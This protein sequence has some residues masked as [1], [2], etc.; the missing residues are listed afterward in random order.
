MP[1][2]DNRHEWLRGYCGDVMLDRID[3]V[4]TQDE[5]FP[6]QRGVLFLMAFWSGPAVMG[7]KNLC[8]FFSE[9]GF[10]EEFTFRIL[11]IDGASRSLVE[12]L[13]QYPVRIGGNAEAYW[14]R[15][16]KVIAAT[17]VATATQ[18]RI[19]ELLTE[20]ARE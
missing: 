18:E 17:N 4:A 10:P 15:D 5:E 16:G 11:D 6:L 9:L 1:D 13:H 20:I 7:L 2:D 8:F 14:Y 12:T 19:R 3:F